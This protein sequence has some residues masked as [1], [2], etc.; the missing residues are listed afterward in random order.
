MELKLSVTVEYVRDMREVGK[1]VIHTLYRHHGLSS[2]VD[3]ERHVLVG[4][5]GHLYLGQV[6]DLCQR[7]VVGRH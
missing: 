6:P 2:F 7:G 1:V 3:S 4:I 5:S